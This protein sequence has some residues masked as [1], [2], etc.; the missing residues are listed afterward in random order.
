MTKRTSLIAYAM[1]AASFLVDSP[2]G[3]NIRKVI[4]FGS[5]ARGDF[6]AASD[7]DLFIDADEKYEKQIQKTL[8]L[9]LQSAI[10]KRWEQKGIKNNI[11]LKVGHLR[12]WKLRREVISSGVLLYG[13]YT[14]LPENAEPYLLIRT[15]DM[16]KKKTAQQVKI[17]RALYGYTQKVGKKSYET[18][19][20]IQQA[21]GTKLGRGVFVVPMGQRQDI[22]QF[23]NKN[24]IQYTLHELW[25]D[26]DWQA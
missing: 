1:D 12:A 26:T 21:G 17:W 20:L 8:Q 24:K 15:K 2:T 9:F 25:S 3:E 5:V 14:E 16:G 10:N 7:I 13:K 11:S 18:V 4:L 23:L 19:G 22:I 6:A